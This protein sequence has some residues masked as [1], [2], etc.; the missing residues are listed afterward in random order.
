MRP[1]LFPV[2]CHAMRSCCKYLRRKK[3]VFWAISPENALFAPKDFP[4]FGHKKTANV[5]KAVSFFEAKLTSASSLYIP[6]VCAQP[7]RIS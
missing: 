6:R 7:G 3:A 5:S 1:F 2:L 4:N